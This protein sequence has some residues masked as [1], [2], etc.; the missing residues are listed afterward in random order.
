MNLHQRR[1]VVSYMLVHVTGFTMKL[2]RASFQKADGDVLLSNE[3][4]DYVGQYDYLE[5]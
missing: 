4:L 2:G 5:W 3:N 1:E